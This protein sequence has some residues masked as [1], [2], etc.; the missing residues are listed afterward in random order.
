[1]REVRNVINRDPTLAL[2]FENFDTT[3]W[4]HVPIDIAKIASANYPD[5][6]TPA[7]QAASLDPFLIEHDFILALAEKADRGQCRDYKPVITARAIDGRYEILRYPTHITLFTDPAPMVDGELYHLKPRLWNGQFSLKRCRE[8][9]SIQWSIDPPID[10]FTWNDDSETFSGTPDSSKSCSNCLYCHQDE[11]NNGH[12][13][14]RARIRADV[15]HKFADENSRYCQ[16]VY[17]EVNIPLLP[18]REKPL[19][20]SSI[21]PSGQHESSDS[22]Y[23]LFPFTI[24]GSTNSSMNKTVQLPEDSTVS[25]ASTQLQGI[26]QNERRI[27]D[28]AF[29]RLINTDPQSRLRLDP[30]DFDDL[31]EC[32]APPKS[33]KFRVSSV[34]HDK[35]MRPEQSSCIK[36]FTINPDE[37][38]RKTISTVASAINTLSNT[39]ALVYELT[40][41]EPLV[42]PTEQF[43]LAQCQDSS[44]KVDD[45]SSAS[46]IKRSVEHIKDL[47]RGKVESVGHNI[48]SRLRD[49]HL[50]NP[51][52]DGPCFSSDTNSPNIGREMCSNDSISGDKVENS[53]SDHDE[54]VFQPKNAFSS[55]YPIRA[56]CE[57]QANVAQGQ[58]H[59]ES[60][61]PIEQ[62]SDRLSLDKQKQPT[63]D[64]DDEISRTCTETGG[65]QS[66]DVF[67]MANS[68]LR[69]EYR[70]RSSI[71]IR[72][73][74]VEP[75]S[76]DSTDDSDPGFERRLVEAASDEFASGSTVPGP[77]LDSD[78]PQELKQES[79]VL[80]HDENRESQSVQCQSQNDLL[81]EADL[82][83]GQS[84][85][86]PRLENMSVIEIDLVR[87]I[88]QSEVVLQTPDL[89]S[90]DF[91][92]IPLSD[93]D[94]SIDM[95]DSASSS[96]F[97]AITMQSNGRFTQDEVLINLDNDEFSLD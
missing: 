63:Y 16:V 38:S 22:E 47:C 11:H 5:R 15:I 36:E 68:P 69:P 75:A 73:F 37:Y 24:D 79:I 61:L 89:T 74:K 30:E 59:E 32:L 19:S 46:Q 13:E 55:D 14:F 93:S 71:A 91:D 62:T 80:G 56:L 53:S 29:M 50:T 76:S 87:D 44:T 40:E 10:W 27:L 57:E 97:I 84:S 1:M 6:G 34:H 65:Q 42:D 81:N 25:N 77:Y 51:L 3:P 83:H 45:D 67:E 4:L 48:E 64:A 8:P 26:R 72:Q 20:N 33:D 86:T 82:S 85:D 88:A 94:D 39:D 21:I 90:D 49:I 31:K 52:P 7:E 95:L 60:C 92:T 78:V 54:I 58:A 70:P 66:Q 12:W 41:Y 17:S 96:P 2:N 18:P 35:T 23:T 43:K 28:D 9:P